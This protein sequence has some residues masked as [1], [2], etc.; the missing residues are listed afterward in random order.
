MCAKHLFLII[1]KKAYLKCGKYNFISLCKAFYC[2]KNI[3][4]FT[5]TCLFG[6]AG[7]VS[8]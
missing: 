7:A 1:I 3:T 6:K 4:R 2:K 5:N 8:T